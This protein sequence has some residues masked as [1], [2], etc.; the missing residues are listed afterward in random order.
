MSTAKEG[1]WLFCFA[2]KEEAEPFRRVAQDAAEG[3]L[4]VTGMGAGNARSAIAKALDE[5][6]PSAVVTSGFAGGLNPELAPL[7][8]VFDADA[9]F[10]ASERVLAR[11]R[12][13]RAKFLCAPK[14]LATVET[15]RVARRESGADA[16]EMES[17]VIREVCRAR[18]IPSA[19]VRVISDAADEPLPL[20]FGA[21]MTA[22]F[23]MNYW[24]LAGAL[25][26]SPGKI[27][28]LMRF[29][30]RVV[31]AAERLAQ[32]LAALLVE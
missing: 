12:A 7:T 13:R 9:D 2:V 26:K 18:G 16:V 1:K 27:A 28:E 23:E 14:V 21:L 30:K 17:G 10:P 29:R 4:L 15:K 20:D 32:A 8:V 3:R 25:A 5:E 24:R 22:Q 11:M 6:Q 31:A 19:T